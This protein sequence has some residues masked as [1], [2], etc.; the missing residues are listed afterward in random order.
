MKTKGIMTAALICVCVCSA[1]L[2]M[3]GIS[4]DRQD[5]TTTIEKESTD[6][7]DTSLSDGVVVYYFHGEV[8]CNTCRTI[9]ALSHRTLKQE[10]TRALDE[11]KIE[12]HVINIEKPENEHF[13]EA[14]QMFTSSL[15]IQKIQD[16][17]KTDWK[18]LEKVWDLVGDENA[19]M[20]YVQGEIDTLLRTG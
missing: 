1:S 14:Y 4:C 3:S 5:T 12:W 18:T 2:I 10:F 16:G 8:R 15:V 20:S 19:F 6:I 13:V 11:G 7:P 9:E 17:D